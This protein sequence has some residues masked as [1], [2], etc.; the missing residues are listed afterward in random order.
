MEY[1]F[2]AY[3]VIWVIIFGYT[4]IIGNR[5][6]SIE[7]DILHLKSLLGKKDA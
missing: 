6:R 2:A 4:L 5:Q 3:T 1:L 7:N